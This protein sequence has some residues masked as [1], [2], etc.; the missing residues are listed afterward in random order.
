MYRIVHTFM[1]TSENFAKKK[2]TRKKMF[3]NAC[4][5]LE[6]L[7]YKN[8]FFAWDKIVQTSPI[9]AFPLYEPHN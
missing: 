4:R 1:H 6:V 7:N 3:L 8:C 5:F 2:R 9:K